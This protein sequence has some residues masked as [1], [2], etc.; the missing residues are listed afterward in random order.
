MIINM[1]AVTKAS[2]RIADPLLTFSTSKTI[3]KK[4]EGSKQKQRKK[5]SEKT[6]SHSTTNCMGERRG[7]REGDTK[8]E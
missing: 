5:Q 7:D 6:L 4:S 2:P 3:F 8:R 1:K